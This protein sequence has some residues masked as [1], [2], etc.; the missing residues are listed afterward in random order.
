MQYNIKW[1]IK[2]KLVTIMAIM[3]VLLVTILTHIQID[4]QKEILER[5][6]NKRIVLKKE[7]LIE[8]GKSIA[9]SLAGQVENNIAALNFSAVAEGIQT[10]ADNGAEII[11]A[12]LLDASGT[13]VI[14]T[15]K[16]GLHREIAEGGRDGTI[17]VPS[18]IRTRERGEGK[19]AVLEITGPIQVSATP[20]GVLRLVFSL[21]PLQEE[22]EASRKQIRQEISKIIYRSTATSLGFMA[23]SFLVVFVL[24]TRVVR[25]LTQLTHL[26][27][28]LSRGD[29]SSSTIRISSRDEVG[30]LAEAFTGMSQNLKDMYEKLE[31]YNKTLEL[32]IEKRTE[33]LKRAWELAD[34]ANRSKSEFLANMSHEIRT[35]M[36]AIMGLTDLALKTSLT[37][38]QRD[39]L[40]KIHTASRALLG[41]INDILDFS[42]IEAGRLELES[43]DFQL[44]D[45]MN[46]VSDLLSDKAAEKGIELVVA[47]GYDI[48]C[49]LVGDPFRLTQILTNLTINAIKF[50]DKGEVVLR[51]VLDSDTPDEQSNSI[52]LTFSVSDTGMGISPEQLPKLF[53]A[54]I[55]A[56]GSTTRKYGGTGLGLA[57]C[58]RLV[59]M[60]GGEIWAESERGKGTTFHFTATFGC[61]SL[62]DESVPGAPNDLKGMRIMVVDDN[63]TSREVLQEMLRSLGFDPKPAGSGKEALQ[64]MRRTAMSSPYKLVLM[65]WKRSDTDGIEMLKLIRQDFL[66]SH[67]R[68]IV[69]ATAP[70]WEEMTRE[71]RKMGVGAFLAK[72]ISP[73]QLFDVILQTV[74]G[75]NT[76]VSE[77]KHAVPQVARAEEKI[78][79]SRV[80]LVEDSA[81]NRQVAVEILERSGVLVESAVNGKK[82][83]DAV[84]NAFE[85]GGHGFDAVL[86]DIQMPE[87]DGYEASRLIRSDPRFQNLTIIAMTAHALRGDKE[88]CL[89]AGMNDYIAKPIDPDQLIYTL[90]QWMDLHT[91]ESSLS[92]RTTDREEIPRFEGPLTP[93]APA[94]NLPGI[95]IASALER[96]GG[97]KALLV[98][99]LRSFSDEYKRAA[100]EI[101]EA[102]EK[103]DLQ[104]ARELAHSIKGVAGNLSATDLY[105][106][107]SQLE[108]TIRGNDTDSLQSV[109]G[110]FE[111]ALN[112][113]LETV[114]NMDKDDGRTA[115]N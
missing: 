80:L 115:P 101:R 114:E 81:L 25:P 11:A 86:M 54:F 7:N 109:V 56:N 66:L 90:A 3:I 72:P 92:P 58:K 100:S 21:E 65:D 69:M 71:V 39:Y 93:Q 68:V 107:A 60:M 62:I 106:A 48:P 1:S 37:A 75:E 110:Y 12:T 26:A 70:D 42:K 67:I 77:K 78:R 2:W 102:L 36:N 105:A 15:Q 108:A 83:V 41:V 14:H 28:R 18:R 9:A 87:M 35:P 73:P 64:E 4:L 79:G 10:A 27:R 99:L 74:G 50:T 97:N 13:V 22:T 47:A 61:R 53:N 91:E 96:I 34:S 84:R 59:Q 111:N 44:Q 51:A 24:F 30:V 63:E 32:R 43:V 46:K 103:N 98:R 52:K 8:R 23:A 112:R 38:R 40:T 31:E 17:T 104:S 16:P 82:A 94:E 76:G 5:E 45:V 6:L 20:W 85:S 57:I 89:K 49:L 33:D 19:L 29:F 95:D 113:V 88:K 55:Q